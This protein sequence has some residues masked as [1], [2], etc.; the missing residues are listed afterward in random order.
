[1][2]NYGSILIEF[3]PKE[4][5]YT[6]NTQLF[7]R[8]VHLLSNREN[9]ITDIQPGHYTLSLPTFILNNQRYIPINPSPSFD[10]MEGE[11]TML[12]IDYDPVPIPDA[13]DTDGDGIADEL[14][15]GG[16]IIENYIPVPAYDASGNPVDPNKTIYRSDPANMS[17]TRDP[18]N[19]YMKTTGLNMDA[20][21][22]DQAARQPLV[23]AHPSVQVELVDVIVTPKQSISDKQGNKLG[24][25]FS[26]T[27]GNSKTITVSHGWNIGG[28]VGGK[29][30]I[31]PPKKPEA[32]EGA[33]ET[34]FT[35]G[36]ISGEIS[37]GYNQSKSESTTTSN[38][39]TN[40]QTGEFNWETAITQDTVQAASIK[41][42][43]RLTNTGT[44]S[45]KQPRPTF[46][47]KLGGKVIA[48]VLYDQVPIPESEILEPG[49]SS[50]DVIVPKTDTR[51]TIYL[52]LEE[53]KAFEL[54]TPIEI[55]VIAIEGTCM[56]FSGDAWVDG[57][58]WAAHLAQIEEYT[59]TL[60]FENKDGVV[61]RYRVAANRGLP[62]DW[63]PNVDIA[64]ALVL[65]VGASEDENGVYIGGSVVDE[66]WTIYISNQYNPNRY[67]EVL[68]EL[69]QLDLT[70]QGI[71]QV[72][73]KAHDYVSVV[74]PSNNPVP[75][76]EFA[77]YGP[78]YRTVNAS[79]VV[80]SYPIK[81]V[82]ARV[83]FNNV[84]QDVSLT[85]NPSTGFWSNTTPFT[86]EADGSY[87]GKVLAYD[88]QIDANGN[89][90]PSEGEALISQAAY[91]PGAL[92]YFPTSIG[93]VG[94]LLFSASGNSGSYAIAP[95][96]GSQIDLLS[97]ETIGFSS[98][99]SFFTIPQQTI[100]MGANDQRLID[101]ELKLKEW[102]NGNVN[103][104]NAVLRAKDNDLDNHYGEE[105]REIWFERLGNYSRNN[106]PENY[107]ELAGYDDW[108][109]Q[110]D[111]RTSYN[112]YLGNVGFDFQSFIAAFAGKKD[113]RGLSDNLT[114]EIQVYDSTPGKNYYHTFNM[115]FGES[116]KHFT[117]LASHIEE[118]NVWT[119]KV[120][121]NRIN[122]KNAI[123]IIL[124][125]Q[126]GFS[127]FSWHIPLFFPPDVT[128]INLDD[129]FKSVHLDSM[130]V[131][132]LKNGYQYVLGAKNG[133]NRQSPP[134]SK[135]AFLSHS[136]SPQTNITWSI[137]VGNPGE[138]VASSAGQTVQARRL[139]YFKEFNGS[140]E[141]TTEAIGSKLQVFPSKQTYAFNPGGGSFSIGVQGVEYTPTAFLLEVISEGCDPYF[142]VKINEV[143]SY[144]GKADM[145]T[146][147]DYETYSAP[148]HSEIIIVPSS[149]N[150]ANLTVVP[151]NF[152]TGKLIINV[153]GYFNETE[154][155]FYKKLD[156]PV[157][158]E[159]NGQTSL[160]PE[161]N[162][163]P[164]AYILKA[165]LQG[166]YSHNAMLRINGQDT[167][168]LGISD[169]ETQSHYETFAFG[170]NFTLNNYTGTCIYVPQAG[171]EYHLPWEIINLDQQ[172]HLK[173]KKLE[174]IGYFV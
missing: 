34:P 170:N 24:N 128:E 166:P 109:Y 173:E 42:N 47:V 8:D 92:A 68:D 113:T 174:I 94:N 116:Y 125:G 133:E 161:L 142:N 1:M 52:T 57:P 31:S 98:A 118:D 20:T 4:N 108:D 12:V 79:V 36:E 145:R 91:F 99:N 86:A 117:S 15:T 9:L 18:Y 54:G 89:P 41:F 110:F 146:V 14:E 140:S 80:G 27:T 141:G 58:P 3:A 39:V 119:N 163:K 137:N 149:S 167:I 96:S 97:L 103:T 17:T 26:E 49:G 93:E 25:T 162:F 160:A 30:T 148:N 150:S 74:E 70:T 120:K 65:T 112:G 107:Y 155:S 129:E 138:D 131:F 134:A 88:Q 33:P 106:I 157:P 50:T 158:V 35:S 143:T 165:N 63:Q 21:V 123:F 76:V 115:V 85:Y 130:E 45:I 159:S 60:G 11:T 62:T 139:G 29:V 72:K 40:T 147:D 151:S 132:V 6:V 101:M 122:G 16:Y 48:T 102:S 55:E 84:E 7:G 43:L 66:R 69:A 114:I 126:G 78:D 104:V 56:I 95:V 171:S 44:A 154:G 135:M 28:K 136:S 46:N 38:S 37:G 90:A 53:L 153:I 156:A 10:I 75:I 64:E 19:D 164:K 152:T 168:R 23:A 121:L 124:H 73:L 127:S 172:Q 5:V 13:T 81:E 105:I 100:F 71:L 32:S 67:N 82:K 111:C 77:Q 169:Y 83:K 22:E 61:E 144:L 87:E 2:G 59:A 51:E